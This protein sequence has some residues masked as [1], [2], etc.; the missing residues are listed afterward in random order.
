MGRLHR[1]PCD[2]VLGTARPR[3]PGHRVPDRGHPFRLGVRAA[4]Q[5]AHLP[6]QPQLR[7]RGTGLHLG[8]QRQPRRHPRCAATDPLLGRRGRHQGEQPARE[9]PRLRLA[10]LLGAGGLAERGAHGLV[11]P[12][13]PYRPGEL[14]PPRHVLPGGGRHPASDAH[15]GG[16]AVNDHA[17]GVSRRRFLRVATGTSAA[18]VLSTLAPTA[19][20]AVRPRVRVYVLVVDGLRPDE[21]TPAITPTLY[22]LRE[23]GTTFPAARSLPVTETLPNHAM[24]ITGMRPDRTG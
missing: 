18:V 11:R 13:R 24:L 16:P 1:R 7:G 21:I 19:F 22:R 17:T 2:R 6:P 12:R 5:P 9:V 3:N 10:R 15:R 23:E 20:A 14:G 4:R 8:D